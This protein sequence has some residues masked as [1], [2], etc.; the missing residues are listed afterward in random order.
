MKTNNENIPLVTHHDKDRRD[1]NDYD[2]Y[3]TSNTS[4]VDEIAYTTPSSTDSK[5]SFNLKFVS[6]SQTRENTNHRLHKMK[7]FYLHYKCC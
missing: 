2:G 4:T 7:L 3:N 5:G 1:D 6:T